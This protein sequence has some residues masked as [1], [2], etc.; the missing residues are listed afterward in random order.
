M[1]ENEGMKLIDKLNDL[2]VMDRLYQDQYIALLKL[3]VKE[4]ES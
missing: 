1:T 4:I 2:L 3:V